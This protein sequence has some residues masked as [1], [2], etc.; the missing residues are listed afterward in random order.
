MVTCYAP[1]QGKVLI[2]V[3]LDLI[4][5]LIIDTQICACIPHVLILVVLDLIG[6]Q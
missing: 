4:G 5:I 6:I 3:V 2:L 1:D